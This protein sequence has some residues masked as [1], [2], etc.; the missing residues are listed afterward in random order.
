MCFPASEVLPSLAGM[1]SNELPELPADATSSSNLK[2]MWPPIASRKQMVEFQ[3]MQFYVQL[4]KG[5]VK[6]A[7]YSALPFFVEVW[8]YQFTPRCP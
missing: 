6:L 5:L 7:H 1:C 3:R 4:E 8:L 2:F